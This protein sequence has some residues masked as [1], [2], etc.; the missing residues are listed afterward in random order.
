VLSFLWDTGFL[1][2]SNFRVLEAEAE[3]FESVAAWQR[4]RPVALAGVDSYRSSPRRRPRTK[5]T[6]VTTRVVARR[7]TGT[8]TLATFYLLF[9]ASLPLLLIACANVA[10]LLLGEAGT[11]VHEIAVRQALGAARWRVARR[12]STAESP[13]HRSRECGR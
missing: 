6:H 8:G 4:A 9:G 3:T 7:S 12:A 2:W 5:R 11:R 10:G 1:S 13:F